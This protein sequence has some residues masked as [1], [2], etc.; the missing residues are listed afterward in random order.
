MSCRRLLTAETIDTISHPSLSA[1]AAQF[2]DAVVRQ[3]TRMDEAF[4]IEQAERKARREGRPVALGKHAAEAESSE[5][6]AKRAKLE[7]VDEPNERPA[8]VPRQVLATGR[9]IDISPL[10]EH[11]VIELVIRGLEAISADAL[12]QI[13][14]VSGKHQVEC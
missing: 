7:P 10:P 1:F 13:L 4:V 9:E 5:T 11:M 12:T 14:N 6:A 8:P 2:K 3:K